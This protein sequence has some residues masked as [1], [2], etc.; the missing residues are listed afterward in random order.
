M[1]EPPL[2]TSSFGRKF[3]IAFCANTFLSWHCYYRVM[4]MLLYTCIGTMKAFYSNKVWTSKPFPWLSMS[5]STLLVVLAEVLAN[6]RSAIALLH[7]VARGRPHRSRSLVGEQCSTRHPYRKSHAFYF[8]A[9]HRLSFCAPAVSFCWPPAAQ[10]TA[11]PRRQTKAQ[12]L[13]L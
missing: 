4:W 3:Y 2:Y 13:V 11:S 5:L 12:V 7:V 6:S 9:Q 10:L 8:W 1:P